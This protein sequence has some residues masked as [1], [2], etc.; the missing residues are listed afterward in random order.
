M[1][2]KTIIQCRVCGEALT[3]NVCHN[4]G[5][6]RIIFPDVIPQ[7]ISKMEEERIKIIKERLKAEREIKIKYESEIESNKIKIENLIQ[8][9]NKSKEQISDLN[10]RNE[11]L[12]TQIF[13]YQKKIT[14]LIK[15]NEEK[16]LNNNRILNEHIV[17]IK[18]LQGKYD[19]EKFISDDL[20]L[21]N[22]KLKQRINLL[23]NIPENS[24]KGVIIIEDMSMRTNNRSYLAAL[25]IY[26]GINTYGS[27]PDKDLH[28][29]IKLKVRGYKF[30]PVHFSIQ[31]STKGFI[32][33]INKKVNFYQNGGVIKSAIYA[34]QSDNFI[35]D[36]NKVRINISP[37]I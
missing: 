22:E 1:T 3:D 12:S 17:K 7:S 28:H 16:I 21:T 32:L 27:D 30:L 33:Q 5:Y 14:E 35:S 8:Q 25:P 10:S 31:T 13:V 19:K 4:C 37:F 29:Q 6:V 36:D 23:S 11:D 2:T 24:L 34:R 20:R 15:D 18:E 26:D 9:L